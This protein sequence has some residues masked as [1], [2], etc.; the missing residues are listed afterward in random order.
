MFIKSMTLVV[1]T[2]VLV[3]FCDDALAWGFGKNKEVTCYLDEAGNPVVLT[4]E[5]CQLHYQSQATREANETYRTALA[6]LD[7][8]KPPAGCAPDDGWCAYQRHVYNEQVARIMAQPNQAMQ[9]VNNRE[10][11]E[12]EDRLDK[13]RLVLE[14]ATLGLAAYNSIHQPSGRG[15]GGVSFVGDRVNGR[16]NGGGSGEAG[17][18]GGSEVA[19]HGDTYQVYVE[20]GARS[21][22]TLGAS[23]STGLE[24][25]E[26]AAQNR[27]VLGEGSSFTPSNNA[28]R[29]TNRTVGLSE[30]F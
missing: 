2:A 25:Y 14:Y 28:P 21:Q 3:V 26:G 7:L 29:S 18:G 17:A 22:I 24:S 15:I 12:H 19:K 16:A 20:R 11:R 30:L 13:R 1:L 9:L 5:V 23:S 4:R 8:E 10:E 6:E 27:P